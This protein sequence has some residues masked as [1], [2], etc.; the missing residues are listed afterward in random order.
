MF[1]C[2]R[3]VCV[4]VCVRVCVRVRVRVFVRSDGKMHVG[5]IKVFAVVGYRDIREDSEQGRTVF[6]QIRPYAD[7]GVVK[8]DSCGC[9]T[10]TKEATNSVR[11]KGWV[12]I[13]QMSTYMYQP[14]MSEI[15]L[16]ARRTHPYVKVVPVAKAF[17]RD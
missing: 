1:T 16:S 8:I 4:C 13:S 5:K 11:R 15:P 2:A 3:C 9:Y 17:V 14:K 12:H 7:D 6:V 10:F